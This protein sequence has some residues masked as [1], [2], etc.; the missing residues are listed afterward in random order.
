MRD[1]LL[2]KW[3]QGSGY[4]LQAATVHTPGKGSLAPTAES[5]P[6]GRS[7]RPGCWIG[8][9]L[10]WCQPNWLSRLLWGV[11]DSL[12]SPFGVSARVSGWA[13]GKVTGGSVPMPPTPLGSWAGVPGWKD[14]GFS[15]RSLF[16]CHVYHSDRNH[17]ESETGK[18]E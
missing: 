17:T 2:E 10:L 8:N 6:T 5:H 14:A 9:C 4:Y 13:A 7:C 15:Q 18:L 3:P 1:S 11:R 16:S 12:G